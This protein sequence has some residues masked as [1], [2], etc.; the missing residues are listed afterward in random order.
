MSME[1]MDSFFKNDKLLGQEDSDI[2]QQ[3][4]ILEQD[5]RILEGDENVERI[6]NTV[7]LWF[8]AGSKRNILEFQKAFQIRYRNYDAGIRDCTYIVR[9][10]TFTDLSCM[11]GETVVE[12]DDKKDK[13]DVYE[14]RA[15]SDGR[16]FIFHGSTK[17]T[18][19]FA[20]R[21]W[22]HY[23]DLAVYADEQGVNLIHCSYGYKIPRI[24]IYLGLKKAGP[25]FA[26]ILEHLQCG[27]FGIEMESQE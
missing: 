21:E 13:D 1:K 4:L 19:D 27:D 5:V 9:G 12:I 14:V 7:F 17:P 15:Y 8:Q 10:R 2:K 24:D 18:F 22:D 11:K 25:F 16:K 23:G 6:D 3:K 26:P 20:D